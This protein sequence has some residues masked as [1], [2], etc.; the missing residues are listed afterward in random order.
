MAGIR[1]RI[2]QGMGVLL[3]GLLAV[4]LAGSPV[5]ASPELASGIVAGAIARNPPTQTLRI[6]TLPVSQLPP[7]ARKTLQLIRQGGP[8][9]YRQDGTVFGNRERRLPQA[10]A[11]YYREYTVPPPGARDRGPRRLITGQRQEIYYTR[12]HYRSFM[13]VEP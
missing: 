5:L 8:F 10:K 1:Q 9:P 12:D 6:P 7:E 3:A 4:V 11:G 2:R 13:Q